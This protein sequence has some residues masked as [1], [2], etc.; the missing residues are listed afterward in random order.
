MTKLFAL[1]HEEKHSAL[2]KRLMNH[3]EEKLDTFHVLLEVDRS[4]SESAKLRGRIAEIR[5]N[6]ALNKDPIKE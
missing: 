6:I 4:E 2:W 3:W 1:S 5:S